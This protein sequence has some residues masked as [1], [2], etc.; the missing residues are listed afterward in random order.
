MMR[1]IPT[2]ILIT[3]Q[4]SLTLATEPY[5]AFCTS[6]S[7]FNADAPV[8]Y[9]CK[10]TDSEA[11]RKAD[12]K[13]TSEGGGKCEDIDLS[14]SNACDTISGF[15]Y[16]VSSTCEEFGSYVSLY[17]EAEAY[18]KDCSNPL[19]SQYILPI[20]QDTCCGGK[21][22][23]KNI[24]PNTIAPDPCSVCNEND[25]NIKV[26]GISNKCQDEGSA[27]SMVAGNNVP[28]ECD[29]ETDDLST[30]SVECKTS[31]FSMLKC[32]INPCKDDYGKRIEYHNDRYS[33]KQLNRLKKKYR[34]KICM[35]KSARE[36]CP[37]IC[38]K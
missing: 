14:T 28:K 32:S 16:E 23:N 13:Y 3:V 17:P 29:D 12:G 9:D 24:C 26:S 19:V 11:C 35:K 36:L 1:I 10:G 15:E 18:F 33:C 5:E 8:F 34:K 38:K 37:V 6:E 20:Y 2:I 21:M 25:R 7:D 4:W 31:F 27:W 22:N 30:V